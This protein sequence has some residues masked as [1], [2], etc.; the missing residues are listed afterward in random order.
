MTRRFKVVFDVQGTLIDEV[1]RPR[2]EVV[3]LLR[4][5]HA[6]GA[7]IGVHSG[8]SAAYCY[9]VV[10]NLGLADLVDWYGSKDRQRPGVDLSVDDRD[11]GSLW[12]RVNLQVGG[13]A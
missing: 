4:A 10:S 8:M 9:T 5:L 3:D 11:V 7:E 1:G 2:R 6:C 13:D 12:A